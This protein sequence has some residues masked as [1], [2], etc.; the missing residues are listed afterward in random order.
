MAAHPIRTVL[1]AS[2]VAVA[3]LVAPRPGAALEVRD[4]SAGTACRPANGA[5]A[6]KFNYNL[7]YLTNI[8]T[9][10]AYV[11]CDVALDDPSQTPDELF[12]LNVDL[13]VP[14]VG[15]TVTCVAQVGSF[16]S[17][18]AHIVASSA[19][20][21][22]ANAADDAIVLGWD[23]TKLVRNDVFKVLTL[24]CKLPPGTKM[25]LIQ[26]WEIPGT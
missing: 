18:Q 17:G 10:D 13:L 6:P 14:T 7:H 11:V 25:G 24:N 1:F 9:V 26:R 23:T 12:L 8:G 3:G 5:L 16:Y 22:T 2:I 20:S 15:H 19:V 21:A 4:Y